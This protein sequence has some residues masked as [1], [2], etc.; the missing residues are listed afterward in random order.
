MVTG[1]GAAG[2]PVGG[3]DVGGD[4]RSGEQPAA[5]VGQGKDQYQQSGGGDDLADDVS[6]AGAVLVRGCWPT[7]NMVLASSAPQ[8]PPTLCGRG[9]CAY[10]REGRAGAGRSAE[11][12]VGDR[13]DR[14]EVRSE[15]RAEH[16]DQY[17]QAERGG[18]K[19]RRRF[20]APQQRLHDE[21]LSIGNWGDHG[22]PRWIRHTSRGSVTT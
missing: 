7:S 3:A 21:A 14:V 4:G 20:P 19:R 15:D 10:L 6:A 13:D 9:V 2:E 18:G 16:Q 5:G 1:A 11:E 12:I 22:W 17:C 8:M